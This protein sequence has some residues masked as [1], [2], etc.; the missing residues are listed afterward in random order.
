MLPAGA[1]TTPMPTTTT[2]A[3]ARLIDLIICIFLVLCVLFM[4]PSRGPTSANQDHRAAR[5]KRHTVRKIVVVEVDPPDIL[6]PGVPLERAGLKGNPAMRW[7][8]VDPARILRSGKARAGIASACYR[9]VSSQQHHSPIQQPC[10][11]LCFLGFHD[12]CRSFP[13]MYHIKALARGRC[14]LTFLTDTRMILI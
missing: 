14:P 1:F 13:F 12:E 7:R 3:S 9:S 4:C 6:A 5:L 10:H 8:N 2:D 11:D